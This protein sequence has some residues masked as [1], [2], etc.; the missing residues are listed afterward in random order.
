MFWVMS[1]SQHSWLTPAVV[2]REVKGLVKF[3][4]SAAC[5]TPNS[6]CSANEQEPSEQMDPG[7]VLGVAAGAFFRDWFPF[8]EGP[9]LKALQTP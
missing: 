6:R 4:I 5:S 2:L 3:W 7:L 1:V 9:R 8:Q